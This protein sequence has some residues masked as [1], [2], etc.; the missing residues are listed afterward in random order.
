MLFQFIPGSRFVQCSNKNGFD[1]I[2][3]RANA[4]APVQKNLGKSR[5]AVDKR[6]IKKQNFL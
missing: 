2:E 6:N 4:V 1:M 3:S 5:Q